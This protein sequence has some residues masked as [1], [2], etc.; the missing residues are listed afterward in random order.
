MPEYV[1]EEGATSTS[2]DPERYFDLIRRRHVPFLLALIFGW[3][4]VW[5][6]SW[7]LPPRYKSTTLILVQQPSMPKD[8]VTPNVSD[9][10]QDRL[11]SITQQILSRT[12]LVT[13][14]EKLNLYQGG[15]V[16]LTPDDQVALMQKDIDIELVRDASDRITAFRVNF[17]A[18]DPRTAQHVTRLLTELFINENLKT[19]QQESEDTT[20]FIKDQLDE[21]RNVLAEQEA[22]VRAFETQHEG[23][24]PTQQATNL[25]ILAG[26]QSQLQN[27]QDALNG[28]RQQR[29]YYEALLGQYSTQ[30]G[31][32]HPTTDSLQLVSPTATID[33]Q[34]DLLQAKL[35]NLRSHYTEQ[36][37]DVV[38]TKDEIAKL[39]VMRQNVLSNTK[40]KTDGKSG[41][42]SASAA[43]SSVLSPLTQVRGQI[44]AN[45][46]EIS[47][48]EQTIAGLKT[49]IND[50]Q[51]RLNA[52]PATQQQLADLTRGYEQSKQNYD[53]LLKKE[54]D[55]EMATNM[56]QM[57][58]GERFTML[59]PPSLPV[60][61]DFPNRLKFCGI[62]LAAGLGLGVVL[63]LALEFFDNRMYSEKEMRA[64]LPV[65]V[66]ASIPEIQSM[67]EVKRERGKMVLGWT[68]AA[69]VILII[70][71]GSAYSYLR[72]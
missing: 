55:S 72:A 19:R 15:K 16:H 40:S 41:N 48:R 7:V 11:A 62:G 31:T 24:L 59:D 47:N 60:K 63:V 21:A 17:S 27:E 29:A 18:G 9:N 67:E 69:V 49:R 68:M 42:S 50:Y 30:V 8:Y 53:E 36:Y 1:E 33:E 5:G 34:L 2:S 35:A 32:A 37:P 22:K 12:R 45:R 66:I 61:P 4:A 43:A 44:E 14:I 54:S 70:A 28:A 6:A 56:E 26:L 20:N 65:P 64:L 3:A 25:Q 13:I 10:L 38:A 46:L 39:E 71:A 52:V 57:Q 51:T 23:E 58:Q